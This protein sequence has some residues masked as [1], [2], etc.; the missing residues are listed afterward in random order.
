MS[1]LAFQS[2]ELPL[3]EWERAAARTDYMAGRVVPVERLIEGLRKH[4]HK[5]DGYIESALLLPLDQY[6]SV[7]EVHA[8]LPDQPGGKIRRRAR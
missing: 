6:R 4:G 1:E 2:E 8:S 5:V 3:E 7:A